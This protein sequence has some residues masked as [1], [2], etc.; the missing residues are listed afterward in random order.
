MPESES[1]KLSEKI[2]LDQLTMTKLCNPRNVS[3]VNVLTFNEFRLI[4]AN[5]G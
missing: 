5:F 2:E 3:S 1:E 4:S